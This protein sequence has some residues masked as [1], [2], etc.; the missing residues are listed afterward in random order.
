MQNTSEIG[1]ADLVQYIGVSLK[2]MRPVLLFRCK[3]PQTKARPTLSHILHLFKR[4]AAGFPIQM[5]N[6]SDKGPADLVLYIGISLKETRPVQ[7]PS[8][9]G[10]A[11]LV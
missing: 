7:N 9:I 4:N 6:P 1:P 2:E 5:Q 3:I 8:D 10:P 11:D